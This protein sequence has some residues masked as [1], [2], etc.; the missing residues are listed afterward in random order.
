[1][2]PLRNRGDLGGTSCQLRG[3]PIALDGPQ[4]VDGTA[5]GRRRAHRFVGCRQI[6]SA[7]VSAVK[8]QFKTEQPHKHLVDRLGFGCRTRAGPRDVRGFARQLRRD[9][10][11]STAR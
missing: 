8:H 5:I 6:V 1:M 3:H 4:S 7:D 11:K 2:R 10:G 9:F